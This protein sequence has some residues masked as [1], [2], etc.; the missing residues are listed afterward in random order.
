MNPLKDAHPLWS[1]T[2]LMIYMAALTFLLWLNASSFD[3]TELRSVVLM[4]LAGGSAEG[5]GRIVNV[6]RR[7]ETKPK[8]PAH[9]IWGM[10]R[11]VIYMGTLC[12]ILWIN[13]NSFDETEVKTIMWMFVVGAGS[14]GIG[15]HMS[16][17]KINITPTDG[18]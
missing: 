10:I 8:K 17:L 1:A 16:R 7:K 15:H 2:R 5:I 6:I 9:P 13:A 18:S 12:L 14:E 3:E 11:S 4:F